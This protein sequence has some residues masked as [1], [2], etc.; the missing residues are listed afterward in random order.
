MAEK[1]A[2]IEFVGDTPVTRLFSFLITGR[3]FD[4][5][6]TDLATK[7]GISWTTL[8]RIL[9]KLVKNK[10]VIETRKIGRIR[11]YKIND[12][13]EIVKKFIE[14]YQKILVS[15]LKKFDAKEVLVT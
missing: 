11:L 3:D 7:A 4:Y 14:L 2:F 1:D 6:L 15:Q 8:N 9:P 12:K 5:T 13:N 10:M